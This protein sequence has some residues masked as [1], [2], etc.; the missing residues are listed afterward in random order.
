MVYV[1][2]SGTESKLTECSH[3]S[4]AL[5]RCNNDQ[6]AGVKCIGINAEPSEIAM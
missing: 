5:T 4:L 6:H 1:Y 2:C 3:N